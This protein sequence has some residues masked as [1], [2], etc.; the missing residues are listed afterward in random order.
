[1][2]FLR[3]HRQLCHITH[4]KKFAKFLE[5]LATALGL[6]S[7]LFMCYFS[8]LAKW[9]VYAGT[10][11]DLVNNYTCQCNVGFRGQHCGSVIR[12]CSSDA[13]FP[14]VRCI[15]ITNTITCDP[16]P[17]GYFGDGKNCKGISD[18][19]IHW[20]ILVTTLREKHVKCSSLRFEITINCRWS[21]SVT[22]RSFFCAF[23]LILKFAIVS[24]LCNVHASRT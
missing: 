6:V 8:L 14:G 3:L 12:N 1:M 18:L 16:C 19:G 15:Q 9:F 23:C 2:S 22:K 21:L 4:K 7:S 17:T 20:L 13:C 24:K 10:C 5:H 11:V